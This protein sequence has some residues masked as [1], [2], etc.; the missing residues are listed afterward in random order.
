MSGRPEC[1][2]SKGVA[3]G[4]QPERLSNGDYL[5]IYNIDTGYPYKPN[6]LGRCA[7]GWAIL[8]GKDPSVIVARSTEALLTASLPWETCEESG[9]GVACQEPE[10]VFSTGLVPLGDD[11]F[12]VIYGG[13]DSDVGAARIRVDIGG[14]TPGAFSGAAF[15]DASS[16]VSAAASSAASGAASSAASGAASGVAFSAASSTCTVVHDKVLGSKATNIR[17]VEAASS[18]ACCTLCHSTIGCAV[19]TFES[20]SS[21]SLCWLKNGTAGTSIDRPG[22]I[23]GCIDA[24]ECAGPPP[25]A[26]DVAV[27]VSTSVA[28]NVVDVGF[29]CWNIDASPNREWDT[30]DLSDPLLASLGRQSLPGHLRF[31]GSGNDGL[32]YALDMNTPSSPGN[33]CVVG[34]PRCLN[35]TWVDNL[36]HFAKASRARL[37]FGLNVCTCKKMQRNDPKSCHGQPWDPTESTVL[38]EYMVAANHTVF[39]FELGNEQNTNYSPTLMAANFKVLSDLLV[40]LYPAA[41]SRPK[42]IGPDVHG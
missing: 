6:P 40:K 39:G 41:A 11:E 42:I 29:K 9:R 2:D 21:S 25:A 4:P 26:V 31:G 38:I 20:S 12:L 22:A 18:S 23:S 16:A 19:W 8:D 36:V 24:A 5:Y 14:T 34:S 27:S 1:W 28:L 7:I 17:R 13:A 32:P 33:K 15:S 35:R 10:V 30:R 37:V 3:A